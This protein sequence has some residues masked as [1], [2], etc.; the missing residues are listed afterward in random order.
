MAGN[1]TDSPQFLAPPAVMALRQEAD[2]KR[3]PMER[4]LSE[5]MREEREDL[6]EAAEQTL[7]VILDLGL[8]GRI[9]WVSPS[10]RQVVGSPVESVEGR[11]I[12]DVLENNAT[13]FQDAIEAMKEDDSRSRFIRFSVRMGPDSVLKYSP[14]PRPPE[15][16]KEHEKTQEG[17]EQE[18]AKEGTQD[19]EEEEWHRDILDMEAQGIMVFDRSADGSGHS[20]W[21]LRPSTEPREV[22][23]DLPPLL[24]ESLGVGAEVLANYLTNL[25]EAAGKGADPATY[26]PPSPVLCRICERQI[27][28]WW[29]EKHSELCLQEHRAEL[30]VQIAQENLNEHRHAIV[31]VLDALEAQQGR[32]MTGDAGAPAVPQPEYKGLPIGPSPASSAPSS[33]QTSAPNSSPGTPTRSRD[34]STSG[35]GGHARGR[36][37]AVRRPLSRIVE[38]ILD[39]CDTALEISTPALKESRADT[40]DD[41]RTLSPQSESRISQVLQ[42]QSPSSNTLDQE[43]GLAA[44]SADTE[45]AARAKVDAVIRHRRIVEYAERIRIEYTVLVEECITAALSKAERIAAGQLSDSSST[46]SDDEH[47]ENTDT[48]RSVRSISLE[49]RPG[50]SSPMPIPM[51]NPSE[52]SMPSPRTSSIAVSTRSSSPMECPTPR[53]HRSTAG[54]LGTSQPSKRGSLLAESDTGEYSDSSLPSSSFLASAMRTDSP[55]SE[56]SLSRTTSSKERK[57]KSLVLPGLS[58]SPR[59]QHSPARTGGPPQ[60]PLRI[61]KPRVPSGDIPSP[62]VSPSLTTAELAS[63]PSLQHPHHHHHHHRRQSSTASS[64]VAKPPVSPRLSSVSQPQPRPA[65]PSI[66]DFEIIK[67]ISKGAFGSVYLSKKKTTG[68]Y[69]AIKVLKKADMI[70]KNQVTNVKAER[71]IMMWQG[72]SDFV[73]KLY[74]TFSSKDYLYL[75]MEYLN[76]GDCASLVK[77]LGGLPEDWAKKYIA[78]VVL[79]V[80]HLHSRGIVH[81]DLKPDNLLIDQKGHLKL[82]DFGLSRMGLVGRQKRVLKSPN[83]SAPD[84]LKQGPF[85]RAMSLASS[86][87]ASFDLQGSPGSTPLITPEV[88]NSYNQPSYFSL[89]HNPLHRENSRRASGYRSDSGS[90]DA[91]AS[92]FQTFSLTEGSD[93]PAPVPVVPN[94]MLPDEEAPSEPSDSPNLYALQPTVSHASSV[95]ALHNTPPQQSM[96]PP[97]MAL[98]DP[99]DHNRR[100]VGTP[101][102]LAPETING[103]G[104]DEMSDWWSL[105]CIL[106]EFLFGYPPFNAP[107]PDE[108]F[109]NILNRRI[110]WPDCA[111]ELASPEAIDLMNKLMTVKPEERLGANIAEKFPSGGAEIRSHPWFSDIN[112][113]TLLEDKA[114]FVPNVE[115]PEDTEYFDA[116]GATLQAFTEEIED[117]PSPQP[118]FPSAD[119]PDRPHDALFKVR[120]QVNSIKRGLMPLHIPPHVRDTRSRRLSEPSM[121]DDF[122]NFNFKNLP[123]LEKANKDVIQKLRQE[124][125]QTQQRQ[126]ISAVQT[127]LSTSGPSLEGSPPVPMP[128]QRTLSHSKGN[129]RPSSPSNHSQAN[130]SPSRPSQPSSPLLVQFSTGQNHERRKTSGSSST[131]SLPSGAAPQHTS[132]EPSRLTTNIKVGPTVSS[133]VK[134]IRV[135]GQS[136]EKTPSGPRQS[137]V[138]TS[139]TRSQTLGSQDGDFTALKETFMPGHHKRRSQLFDVSPSSSDNEDPRT[140]A[141]LKVQRR[142]QSSRRL[143]NINLSEGPFFRPLDVLICEDHPVSRLVMERLFEK[144]RCRTITAVNGSEAIRYALSEVEFDIIMTEFKLPQINGADV[145]RMV[146][147]TRSAN[148]HT[149]IIAVTGYLKDLPETHHFDALIEKPPTLTKFTEALCK[150]C[151]WKPPPKDYNPAQPLTIPTSALRQSSVRAEDSPSSTSSGFPQLVP[152]S[153]RGSSREDSVGSS[154]FGDMDSIKA[155]EV[156][157]VISRH[158]EDWGS[159]NQGGLGIS[160]EVAAKAANEPKVDPAA[161]VVPQ[162]LHASSAPAY[163]TT[164]GPMTP[165]KQRSSEA[166]RAKRESLEKKRYECAESGDDE[167]EELGHAQVQARSPNNKTPRSGSKLGTEMM[168]TNSRGSVVSGSEEI[169]K[170]EKEALEKIRAG[171]TE[172]ASDEQSRETGGSPADVGLEDTFERLHIPEEALQTV[173]ED[174]LEDQEALQESTHR[175]FLPQYVTQV[176]ASSQTMPQTT[177][178]SSATSEPQT[179]KKGHITPPIIFPVE[180]NSDVPAKASAAFTDMEPASVSRAAAVIGPDVDADAAV[181][182]DAATSADADA[183][184]RPM[185]TPLP[186]EPDSESDPTPRLSERSR[187]GI[188]PW[189]RR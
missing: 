185:H 113:D 54:L 4:T 181:D 90:S 64:E 74:W 151:H 50:P 187:I 152:S 170:K 75:V 169:L 180:C 39:L 119:Y 76:G 175:P 142:R 25:A 159:S 173:T 123:I 63:H 80:E 56:R 57:R 88:S 188:L 67:P 103:V 10:W 182:T 87:S 179:E 157:V 136:P 96:L 177:K 111:E 132:S 134:P 117:Q 174:D 155:E 91:L 12:S 139:R 97:A 156:P 41:F 18:I 98:F 60:S 40:G 7:N 133:P 99:E 2:P 8:D 176:H 26:P 84:L 168:R 33:G 146:R 42:W 61:S 116:R 114:Q 154:Y 6:K 92:M 35:L 65:P 69:F 100:F 77:V 104:Q 43:Q 141:L 184:P 86:R 143:S 22:T 16:E 47:A 23:I 36:S 106:F 66:K 94:K 118:P 150:F 93:T 52:Q 38:L 126:A 27:T 166:I 30:D 145:A 140:K 85:P 48:G 81:R 149:P 131:N 13:A 129:N 59:R 153:Y 172:G 82:T 45:A 95:G 161:V 125:M 83:D 29:F 89:G 51:R 110:N 72:E 34:Q 15:P 68:E 167:D 122:G 165:R 71:A 11:M 105:G 186:S 178:E 130:S 148:T 120:T 49:P 79:G 135:P 137:S 183:T 37:F 108:V 5:D 127:P 107:T 101:D 17:Q 58:S 164:A 44:L 162:L 138:P 112:W 78:E 70:A 28:P 31:K 158:G 46:C 163:V 121:A 144:L 171:N 1:G 147:E 109:E 19:D 3:L 24:V 124:A 21:M 14:E 55:S 128:L 32:P 73:A 115:N 62:V 20:M 102:Y 189:K 160:D 53:S 9:K